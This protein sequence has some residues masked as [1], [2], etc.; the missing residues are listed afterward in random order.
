VTLDALM[1]C[2]DVSTSVR[3]LHKEFSL[4]PFSHCA[5]ATDLAIIE[6]QLVAELPVS[7]MCKES[8]SEYYGNSSESFHSC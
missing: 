5:V 2:T 6:K 8:I 1:Q 7:L 4:V 3:E